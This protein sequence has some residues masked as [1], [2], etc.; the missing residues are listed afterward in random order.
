MLTG[1][2]EEEPTPS[3]SS[4]RVTTYSNQPKAAV[5]HTGG[6]GENMVI[7]DRFLLSRVLGSGSFGRVYKGHD[8]TRQLAVA[9]KI[10]DVATLLDREIRVYQ[11]LWNF[12]KAGFESELKI[13]RVLWEGTAEGKR[14]LVLQRLGPSL[15]KLYDRMGKCWTTSTLLWILARGMRSLRGLH[16]LGVVH[17]DIKPDNFAIGYDDRAALYVLDFGL[18]FQYIQRDGQHVK[19]RP[20]T[21]KKLSLIGTMRYASIPNHLGEQ[22]SRRDDLESLLYTVAYFWRGTLPW[23][24]RARVTATSDT[25][26]DERSR[27][28]LEMKRTTAPSLMASLHPIMAELYAYVRQLRFVERP[29]YDFWLARIEKA[30]QDESGATA[31]EWTPDWS[32]ESHRVRRRSHTCKRRGALPRRRDDDA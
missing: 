21:M 15:D 25:S 2:T 6:N 13:P 9:A 1:A 27:V 17:R 10:E 32:M 22:Q 16:A 7:E 20:P 28:I 8:T 29:R 19:S 12:K 24:R 5:D 23:E 3:I 4:S 31:Q 11:H 30:V 14:V 18:S 26:R